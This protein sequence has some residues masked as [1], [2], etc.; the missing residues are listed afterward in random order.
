MMEHLVRKILLLIIFY[1]TIV[2]SQEYGRGLLLTDSLYANSPVAP[3]LM[4][5]DYHNVPPAYSLKEYAPMPGN[6]GPLSTCAGWSTA[7]SARTILEA[8]RNEWDYSTINKNA[9]SPSFVYNQIRRGTGCS[10]GTSLIDALNVLKDIGAEKLSDFAYDCDRKV[11]NQDKIKAK[12]YKII[13][14]RE[15]ADFRTKN[16]SLYVKKSIAN[17]R[18]VVIAM[19][20]PLSFNYAE[21]VWKPDVEDYKSKIS[22]GHGVTVIGYD[23]NKF[24][25]AFEIMNNWGT[26]W[27][28]NGFTWI[29]YSDFEKFCV[30]AFE[31]LARP[32]KS[33]NV[34]DLQGSL[35][36]TESDGKIMNAKFN[37]Q[38]FITDKS[39]PSG[40]LFELK[41][42]NNE[43]AYVYAF[44]SDNTYMVTKLF[45]LD[46]RTL[47]YLPYSQNNVA[48]PDE[49]HFNI[50]DSTS[51]AAYYCFLY[52]KK[53]LDIDEVINKIEKGS[54]SFADRLNEALNDIQVDKNNID[55]S[56]GNEIKFKAK[57]KGK[58]VVPVLVEIQKPNS[59]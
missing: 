30:Y 6:Q 32:N 23:D 44:G 1:Q 11:T 40:T 25:G 16:K 8:I 34:P 56:G 47:P 38:Y 45:P 49:D 33:L 36:F 14:Y 31:V 3:M 12:D 17:K 50:I 42:S 37:G 58:Y 46:K 29:K 35:R 51:G 21:E 10:S 2:F 9:F 53:S 41:I 22:R 39:Y 13:E 15:I 54:G 7:Y 57:S 24:K 4:R 26:N 28:N 5:G 20:A 59:N 52:S 19:N 48:I 55:F 43:P 18:P 27:G